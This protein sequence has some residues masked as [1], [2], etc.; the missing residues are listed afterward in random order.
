MAGSDGEWVYLDSDDMTASSE[1]DFAMPVPA[2]SGDAA[3]VVTV[4]DGECSGGAVDERN[5][6]DSAVGEE[7]ACTDDEDNYSDCSN[8]GRLERAYESDEGLDQVDDDEEEKAGTEWPVA[9][10]EELGCNWYGDNTHEEEEGA[11]FEEEYYSDDYCPYYFGGDEKASPEAASAMLPAPAAAECWASASEEAKAAPDY[12]DGAAVGPRGC[13]C[14]YKEPEQEEADD[15][16]VDDQVDASDS[17]MK[18]LLL[19]KLADAESE[20][21]ALD[22]DMRKTLDKLRC[23]ADGL[24]ATRNEVHGYG[25]YSDLGYGGGGYGGS[26]FRYPG[27]LHQLGA[28]PWYTEALATARRPSWTWDRGHRW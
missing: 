13:K 22:L 3:D 9:P 14:W 11:F 2:T 24:K 16:D 5:Y 6:A 1:E 4:A 17:D 12:C 27:G 23:I 15:E 7:D 19:D 26:G 8:E 25:G 21:A 10:V 18:K 20:L 28:V